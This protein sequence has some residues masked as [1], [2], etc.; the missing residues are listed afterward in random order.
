[1]HR[2]GLDDLAG[3]E[4]HRPVSLED[5]GAGI[6]EDVQARL[7]E[8]FFT[9][10]TVGAGTGLGLEIARRIVEAHRGT[11][12]FTSEPGRTRFTVRLPAAGAEHYQQ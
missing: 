7:F 11:L 1:M 8:P 4:G 6:P 2:D 9:T 12:A 3:V 5:D 10:K